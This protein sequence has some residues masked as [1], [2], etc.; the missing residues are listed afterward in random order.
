MKLE[1]NQVPAKRSS[2]ACTT[3]CSSIIAENI[4]LG[5]TCSRGCSCGSVLIL[6]HWRCSKDSSNPHQ[7]DQLPTFGSNAIKFTHE[8]KV[9]I[10]LYVVSDP[11]LEE[12][13]RCPQKLNADQVNCF[14]KWTE[15]R[16]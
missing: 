4:D 9:G 8:G 10:R 16:C 3:D 12:G 11:S 14:R 5:R 13:E 6:G 2:E 1:A 15:R 7:L